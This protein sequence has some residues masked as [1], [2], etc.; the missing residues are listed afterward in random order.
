MHYEL[1]ANIKE[2]LEGYAVEDGPSGLSGADIN[3]FKRGSNSFFLKI[4]DVNNRFI[5]ELEI[6]CKILKWLEGKFPAPQII[7]FEKTTNKHYLLMTAVEGMTLEELFQQNVSIKEIVTI[8]AESLKSIHSI[9]LRDCPYKADDE[10]M[11]LNA[12]KNLELG[13]NQENMEEEY[14]NITPRD[15]YYKL[16]TLKPEKNENV[17]IHGDYCLDNIIIKNN[18]LNGIIDVGRGGIGDK[19]K[20]IALAVRNIR[21]D[22]GEQWLDLFFDKYGITDPNW[23]KIEFYII[24]DEFY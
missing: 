18:K 15:L 16:L 23:D 24:M 21:E 10:T 6:E 11:L 17:F 3:K 5:S 20:D 19:Y 13:I 9:D 4:V 2:I 22:L 14:K 8:Y 7:S 12:K 1:P